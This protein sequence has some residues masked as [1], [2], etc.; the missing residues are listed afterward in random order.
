VLQAVVQGLER[1][2]RYFEVLERFAD[3]PAGANWSSV[4]C[5]AGQIPML[6]VSYVN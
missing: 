1:V 5:E 3:M 2:L 4:G 6:S